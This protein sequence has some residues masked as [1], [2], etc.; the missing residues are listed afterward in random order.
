M[1]TL[2][3]IKDIISN[4][5]LS[6]GG[7][8]KP[9]LEKKYIQQFE[10]WLN[11]GY[12]ADMEWLKR[13]KNDRIDI[14][15]KF[16]W[17]KS[18]LV[19]LDNYF[20]D[21]ILTQSEIKITR[22]AMGWDYHDVVEEKLRAVLA[23]IRKIDQNIEGKIFVDSGPVMEKAYAEQAG[24]G[25]IGKNGVFIGEGI[26]SYCFIGI[27][28]LSIDVQRSYKTANKCDSCTLCI[29]RCPNGAIIEPG[30]IDSCRCTAYLTIEK[31]GDFSDTEKIRLNKWAYGCDI[32]QEVCP[33]NH[34]WSK[35][36][37]ESRY[38][39]RKNQI[40]SYIDLGSPRNMDK[41][42][43]VFKNTAIERLTCK[44]MQRNID[45]ALQ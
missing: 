12:C 25:W 5:K 7:I 11:R 6:A 28:L 22:Y 41:F 21:P 40:R 4:N 34:K 29:K 17:V 13:T 2:N 37:L 26:G 23:E 15:N 16:P 20:N 39:D 30:M 38:H 43:L 33:W 14:R 18:V 10:K 24:L 3:Q 44:R 42:N 1:I 8:S 32:C 27:L 35:L 19:V 45:A 36:T 31:R 9:L